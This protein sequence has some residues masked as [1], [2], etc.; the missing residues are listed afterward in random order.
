LRD[1]VSRAGGL[2]K[3][4]YLYA[5]E[6]RRESTRQ[7]QQREMD[8]LI[9]SMEQDLT[10]RARLVSNQ[11]T[12]DEKIAGQQELQYE[13]ATIER[14]KTIQV[15]GRIVLDLKPDDDDISAVPAIALEDGDHFVVPA[16]PATIGVV[17][18]VYNQNSFL[19]NPEYTMA[20][21]L[22]YAGGGT[23]E[24]DKGRLFILRANGSV[25]SNQMHRSIWSGS[26][27]NAKL[28]PGDAIVMP[29]KLKT[30]S[31]LKEIRDWSQALG[32]YAVT[33]AIVATR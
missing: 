30:T 12:P 6:L 2:T 32:Q 24:A 7:R 5:A 33:A 19:Y 25:L 21:Y 29:Q 26:F 31:V 15:T 27:E 3:S 20:R 23:R 22:A 28:Y 11:L 18:S 4:A 1:L 14:M 16:R 8:R 10:T 17:G 9:D 13:R